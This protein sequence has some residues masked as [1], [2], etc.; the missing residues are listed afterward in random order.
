[1]PVFAQTSDTDTQDFEAGRKM[2]SSM[3]VIVCG[4]SLASRLYSF[5]AA[6][7]KYAGNIRQGLAGN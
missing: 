1:M 6:W 3:L 4:K 7:T 5:D 2:G